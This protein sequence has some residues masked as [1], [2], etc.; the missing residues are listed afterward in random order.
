MDAVADPR[1]ARLHS[2]PRFQRLPKQQSKVKVDKRF[3]RL[4]TDKEFQQV[5]T[6]PVDRQGKKAKGPWR[7]RVPTRRSTDDPNGPTPRLP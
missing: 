1:F 2:D 3:S 4:F 5:Q 7:Q 6:A